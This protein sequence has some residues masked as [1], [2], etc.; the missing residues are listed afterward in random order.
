M[1][2]TTY[3][4]IGGQQVGITGNPNDDPL[5]APAA[6]AALKDYRARTGR[7]AVPIR[8]ANGTVFSRGF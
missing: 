7:T 1:E 4:V 2:R 5:S 6:K 8:L 3:I